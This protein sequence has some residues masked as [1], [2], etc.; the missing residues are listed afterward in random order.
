FSN[1]STLSFSV[2]DTTAGSFTVRA[3]N[4]SNSNV[5]GESGLVTVSAAAADHLVRLTAEDP[6][7][8]GNDRLLQFKLEDVYG[9]EISNATVTFTRVRGNGTFSNGLSNISA[10][11][12]GNGIAEALYTASTDLSYGSDSIDVVSGSVSSTYVMTLQAASVSYYTFV[13]STDQNITAGGSVNFTITARDQY[14]N[15]VV[16]SGTVSI[17]TPGSST[18]TVSPSS[19]LSFSNDSTLSFS[20]SDNTAGSFTVRA[21]N[22]SNSNIKGESGLVTVSPAALSYVLIRTEANNGGSEV[23]DLNITTDDAVTMYAAG[24]DQYDNYI[25]DTDVTWSSTGTLESVSATGSKYTFSPTQAGGSGQIVATPSGSVTADQTGTITVST[26]ALAELRLQTAD[27]D[28]GQTLGD[29][30]I[31]ADETLTLYAVGYDADDN[32]IGLT[33]AN[34]SLNGLSG[35]LSPGNPTTSVTFTPDQKGSGS[36]QATASSNSQVS[37]RTGSITVT[38]GTVS[39]VLI[40][41]EA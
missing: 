5:T 14:G 35:T 29:T 30:S 16:N 37:D 26:G 7:T 38:A 27:W 12:D 15:G 33:S 24:Y 23:G 9:N 13:P 17:S 10:T 40:R 18:A 36:L 20:V 2:S 21:V 3:V 39:Y 6:I 41:D 19:S 25:S 8:V 31:T 4:A 1:D 32:Y 34:W 11:T 22:S 28:G